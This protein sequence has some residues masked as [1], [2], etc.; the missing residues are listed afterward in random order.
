MG[1]LLWYKYL[2]LL[3]MKKIVYLLVFLFIGVCC[4]SQEEEALPSKP[5]EDIVEMKMSDHRGLRKWSDDIKVELQG[6]Y[7][8]NDSIK[9]GEILKKLDNVTETISIGFS[10]TER[11]NL[12][13][14][15]SKFYRQKL[16]IIF[17]KYVGKQNYIPSF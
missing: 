10:G 5:W 14:K 6:Y 8:K 11:S 17:V 16:N 3:Q 9:I 4:H 15:F 2:N 7:T 1:V 13:I 12:Q